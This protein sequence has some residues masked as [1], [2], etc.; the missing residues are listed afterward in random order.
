MG[1]STGRF[2]AP[3]HEQGLL[4]HLEALKL[5]QPAD[6]EFARG[7]SRRYLQQREEFVPATQVLID[8]GWLLQDQARRL[9]VGVD[10]VVATCYRCLKRS[11]LD[12]D[13]FTGAFLCQHCHEP[14]SFDDDSAGLG[15]ALLPSPL[16]R[17][18][19][20]IVELMMVTRGKL[21]VD[22]LETIKQQRKRIVPRPSLL[23][24]VEQLGKV[25][26]QRLIQYRGKAMAMLRRK[27]DFAPRL[28]TDF[29]LARFLCNV[30][31]VSQAA[32]SEALVAQI[33]AA[34]QSAYLPL[35]DRL[36][37]QGH[38]TDYQCRHFLPAAFDDELARETLLAEHCAFLGSKDDDDLLESE[39]EDSMAEVVRDIASDSSE[40]SVITLDEPEAG[41]PTFARPDPRTARA[42]RA[43]D[44]F[45]E[46]ELKGVQSADDLKGKR[47][48]ADG[49]GKGQRKANQRIVGKSQRGRQS[50]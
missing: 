14:V 43:Y 1:R 24:M 45:Y 13:S 50:L 32:L 27:I 36:R 47:V 35:R 48:D 25:G 31:V 18:I 17:V 8:R 26:S 16:D 2:R 37:S 19:D 15:D 21:T 33:E 23:E 40:L 11:I 12:R 6:L 39:W 46:N 7:E 28:R 5:V 34:M 41:A 38:L 42:K 9:T 30:R 49:K 29:E 20:K 4:D 3:Q 10:R 44:D 22:E